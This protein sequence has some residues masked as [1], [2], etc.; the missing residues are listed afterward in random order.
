MTRL[1]IVDDHQMVMEGWMSLLKNEEEFE[2]V[3]HITS[4]KYVL[5]FLSS[6]QVDLIIMDI[7][8]GTLEDDGLEAIRNVRKEF[9]NAIKTL[10]V[11]MHNEIGHIQE[12]IESGTNGY[13]LKTS[14]VDDLLYAMRRIMS[15]KSYYS[16]EVTEQVATKMRLAGEMSG[17]Q[18]TKR[19]KV[20]L[21]LFCNGFTV[22]Q[23]GVKM[24]VSENTVNSFKKRIFIK[25]EVHKVSE[26]I[27]KA[28]ELGFAR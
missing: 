23:V 20:A 16:Q 10:V 22:K 15:G 14:S 27:N 24:G 11:S 4:G 9:G 17:I 5:K 12:A 1:L 8:M 6:H 21:P 25:F 3:G 19:E 26:L 2:V 28:R 13:I 7:A 18:L